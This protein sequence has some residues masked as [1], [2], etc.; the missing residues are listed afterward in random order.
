MIS[1][2][3]LPTLG[4]LPSSSSSFFTSTSSSYSPFPLIF[5]LSPSSIV[6]YTG[7]RMLASTGPIPVRLAIGMGLV[8]KIAILVKNFTIYQHN[9]HRT[10]KVASMVHVK[11]KHLIHITSRITELPCKPPGDQFASSSIHKVH[12]IKKV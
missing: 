1:G 4:L 2:T 7:I 9:V 5:L 8:P 6:V 11:H 10:V 12:N 3:S